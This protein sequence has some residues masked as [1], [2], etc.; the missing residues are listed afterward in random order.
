MRGRREQRT[1]ISIRGEDG[2]ARRRRRT[3]K[4]VEKPNGPDERVRVYDSEVKGVVR[5]SCAREYYLSTTTT[6]TTTAIIYVYTPTTLHISNLI[7][8]MHNRKFPARRRASTF[9]RGSRFN[10]S[11]RAHTHTPRTTVELLFIL[12][13][14][15]LYESAPRPLPTRG[16][17]R[18]N[19]QKHHRHQRVYPPLY[20][21]TAMCARARA[22]NNVRINFFLVRVGVKNRL[23]I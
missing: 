20:Y 1:S 13:Y 2:G 17:T 14:M 21:I 12:V 15:P 19:W 5:G 9:E 6:T 18:E 23:Y 7:S 4:V 3:T 22:K 8:H 11:S 16:R 10:F